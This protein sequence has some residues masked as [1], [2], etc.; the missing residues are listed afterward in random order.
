MLRAE[1][2]DLNY[3][4]RA[5]GGQIWFTPELRV[6]YRPRASVRGPRSRSTST[7]AAGGGWSSASTRR[8]PASATWPRPAAAGAGRART[9]GRAWPGWP[10]SRPGGR[11][12]ALAGRRVRDPGHLPGRDHRRRGRAWPGACPAACGPGCRSFS[13][14]CTCAGGPASSPARGRCTGQGKLTPVSVRPRKEGRRSR[15]GRGRMK[16]GLRPPGPARRPS[17]R[18]IRAVRPVP[19]PAAAARCCTRSASTRSTSGPRARTCT[20]PTATSTP[21]SWPA[22]ACSRR[23]ATT[24]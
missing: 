16:H 9:G 22:S 13:A 20:T 8:R 21:T 5:R 12:P 6:T 2:W 4:I 10:Q 14:S 23:A 1:D 19:E 7:T 11:R 15:R 17:R 18:R 24:R 3:R